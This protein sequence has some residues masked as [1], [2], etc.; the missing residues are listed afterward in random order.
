MS[1]LYQQAA[2]GRLGLKSHL[3]R[4][5]FERRVVE[6]PRDLHRLAGSS[7]GAVLVGESLVLADRSPR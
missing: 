1:E 4:H 6:A 7:G 3:A 5:G 2:A